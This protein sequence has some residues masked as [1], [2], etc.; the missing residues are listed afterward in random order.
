MKIIRNN[1]LQCIAIFLFSISCGRHE[2]NIPVTTQKEPEEINLS[3]DFT[4]TI[5]QDILDTISNTLLGFNVVYPHEKDAIWQD[6]KIALYLKNIKTNILRYPGGTVV[7][8]YHWDKLSGHGWDDSWAPNYSLTAKP[9]ADFMDFDQYISLIRNTGATPLVGINMSSGRRWNRQ[10]DGINEA[11]ALM[12]YCTEKNFAV[13]YWYLDNE[14]YQ[15]DSNGGAKT[16][17]EYAQLINAYAQRMKE[18]DPNISLIANWKSDFKGKRNEYKKLFELAGHNID[19]IDVHYYWAWSGPTMD[20]WLLNTPMRR[21]TNDSFIADIAYFR[22][23]VKDFGYPDTRL[24]A[25]EWNLGPIVD[26]ALNSHQAAIIQ[27]EIFLQYMIGGLD[28]AT[29]WPLHWPNKDVTIRTLV[30]SENN[31]PNPN[32]NIFRIFGEIQGNQVLETRIEKSVEKT[33][34]LAA[35]NNIKNHLQIV[36]LNKNESSL[37]IRFDSGL[38]ENML[39]LKGDVFELINSGGSSSFKQM[40][41]PIHHEKSIKFTSPGFSV[42]MLTY[43]KK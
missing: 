3:S 9:K 20:Q 19:I 25:L 31:N 5:D 40:G 15:D 21:W 41:R 29:F 4:A 34:F 22:Q 24:A 14:P 17:E 12:N 39:F 23:M 18:V 35:Y 32:Y 26:N 28:M 43:I 13:K 27:S 8:F 42:S 2:V 7:S 16:I 33:I 11:L 1:H 10:E 30:D 6:G 38:F 36:F 37:D